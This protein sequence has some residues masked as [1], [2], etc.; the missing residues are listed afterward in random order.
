MRIGSQDSKHSSC[1]SKKS[2]RKKER[3]KKKKSSEIL[4]HNKTLNRTKRYLRDG[5][6][7]GVGVVAVDGE[8]L[9]EELG[10][11]GLLLLLTLLGGSEDDKLAL[12]RLQA[13]HV[14]GE[15]RL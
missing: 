10:D 7:A 1:G 15:R 12:V 5:T 4:F 11:E 14:R 9:A 8:D 2:N 13:L 6:G 3:K